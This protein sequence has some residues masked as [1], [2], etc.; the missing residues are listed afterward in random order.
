M[1]DSDGI[2]LA[3]AV[4]ELP[5]GD[6]YQLLAISSWVG[7]GAA[8]ACRAAGFD[9]FLAK[10]LGFF[11]FRNSLR[12]LFGID[13][14]AHRGGGVPDPNDEQTVGIDSV[15]LRFDV[16]LDFHRV[17][18]AL[19]YDTQPF[20]LVGDPDLENVTRLVLDPATVDFL[21]PFVGHQFQHVLAKHQP[22]ARHLAAIGQGLEA[23][24]DAG[25][26]HEMR[27]RIAFIELPPYGK[28]EDS[29]LASET[30]FLTGKYVTTN[31]VFVSTPVTVVTND[32]VMV[33]EWYGTD[34][35]PT[36]ND[37]VKAMTGE[38]G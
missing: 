26:L 9:A 10:P 2:E 33:K 20:D 25:P 35:I 24:D 38:E 28:P 18:Y 8:Q 36:F 21:N 1:P 15:T 5:A 7:S 27:I 4:R 31:K 17:G 30:I 19:Y 22:V 34:D 12:S 3:R 23:G 16:A 13:L 37:L 6:E 14:G 29:P 32:G 11:A